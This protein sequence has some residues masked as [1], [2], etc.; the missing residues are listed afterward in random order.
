MIDRRGGT[1]DEQPERSLAAGAFAVSPDVVRI[2]VDRGDDA[3]VAAC[4]DACAADAASRSG[5][6][7]FA[8][9]LVRR[10]PYITASPDAAETL[11]H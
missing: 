5:R 11:S 6:C 7:I 2:S 4:V 3:G 10:S 8:V 9:D 1:P